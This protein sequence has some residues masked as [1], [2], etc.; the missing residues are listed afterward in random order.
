MVTKNANLDLYLNQGYDYYNLDS[1]RTMRISHNSYKSFVL[2]PVNLDETVPGTKRAQTVQTNGEVNEWVPARMLFR[3]PSEHT[4]EG[5]HMD[6][7]LQLIHR[8]DEPITDEES[9]LDKRVDGRLMVTS[10]FF[11]RLHGGNQQNPF[12]ESLDLDS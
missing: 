4:F 2:E 5:R 3:A 9:F 11:D 8:S 6:L 12:L 10:V 7:E 1:G